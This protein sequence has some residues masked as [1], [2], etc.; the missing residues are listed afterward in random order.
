[1][2]HLVSHADNGGGTAGVQVWLN[3]K[4]LYLLLNF[5]VNL[6]DSSHFPPCSERKVKAATLGIRTVISLKHLIKQCIWLLLIM[7]H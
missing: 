1:M 7:L 3:G 2:Y 4:S 6:Y 5:V